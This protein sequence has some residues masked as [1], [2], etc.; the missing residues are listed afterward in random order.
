QGSY[1][2]WSEGFVIEIADGT[3]PSLVWG[4]WL[5]GSGSD[6]VQSLAVTGDEIYAGGYTNDSSGWESISWQGSYSGSDE[7]FVIEIADGTTPSLAWGQWLGGSGGDYV[8]SLAVT[9]DEIYAGGYSYNP[10][11]WESITF[12][13]SNQGGSE[14]FIV[15]FFDDQNPNSIFFGIHF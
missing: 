14:G 12:Y 13:G 11:L 6:Y 10:S 4:Q 1:S 15:K 5:G 9:G 8:Q 2:G 3:T 7:G